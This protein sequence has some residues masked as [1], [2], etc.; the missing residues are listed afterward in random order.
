MPSGVTELKVEVRVVVIVVVIVEAVVIVV[1]EIVVVVVTVAVVVIAAV[2]EVV[3][4]VVPTLPYP[5]PKN[6]SM[7]A[8][9]VSSYKGLAHLHRHTC[10]Q[11]SGHSSRM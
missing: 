6:I 8:L 9:T 7:M 2:V 10:K 5:N 3:V 1:V 11:N 4:A